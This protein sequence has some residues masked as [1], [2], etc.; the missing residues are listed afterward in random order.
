M[1]GKNVNETIPG[2]FYEIESEPGDATHYSYF[3]IRYYNY[4][5]F[6]PKDNS[7]N[8]PQK[9]EKF[10]AIHIMEMG[11]T[12]DNEL[13]KRISKKYDSS[14][15]TIMECCRTAVELLDEEGDEGVTWDCDEEDSYEYNDSIDEEDY[16]DPVGNNG[17]CPF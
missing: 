4:F 6:A 12:D 15:Y 14:V 13:L 2:K 9:I 8:Y 17:D 5:M 1:S 11:M 16:N 3:C 7:F 10:D